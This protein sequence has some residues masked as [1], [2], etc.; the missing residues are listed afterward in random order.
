MGRESA[1]YRNLKNRRM[2]MTYKW[3]HYEPIHS[4]TLENL[5]IRPDV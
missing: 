5:I 1:I 2:N 4:V 3:Y